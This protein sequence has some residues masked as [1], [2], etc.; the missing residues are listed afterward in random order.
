MAGDQLQQPLCGSFPGTHD[1]RPGRP[2]DRPGRLTGMLRNPSE[3]NSFLLEQKHGRPRGRP[4]STLFHGQFRPRGPLLLG[5]DRS[6]IA[7]CVV[8][9]GGEEELVRLTI[10]DRPSTKLNSPQPGNR[11]HLACGGLKCTQ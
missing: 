5:Y 6:E 9:T 8:G 7:I 11:D 3:G 10:A 1:D 2:L 4:C